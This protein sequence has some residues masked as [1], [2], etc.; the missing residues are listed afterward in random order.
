MRRNIDGD[1]V[2]SRHTCGLQWYFEILWKSVVSND[3]ISTSISQWHK[4]MTHAETVPSWFLLKLKVVQLMWN[5]IYT[6]TEKISISSLFDV[7][8]S[9][10]MVLWGTKRLEILSNTS[11]SLSLSG[12]KLHLKWVLLYQFEA[13]KHCYSTRYNWHL[14]PFLGKKF[15]QNLWMGN[16]TNL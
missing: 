15:Y 11:T 1:T 3:F 9:K 4:N 5:R 13:M 2:W 10:G 6:N 8:A 12:N 16:T 14:F 7:R